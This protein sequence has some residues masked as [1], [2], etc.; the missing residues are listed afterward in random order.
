M[1]RRLQILNAHDATDFIA[2]KTRDVAVIV[3]VWWQATGCCRRWLAH[4]NCCFSILE[5]I[6]KLQQ[7][8]QSCSTMDYSTIE[9]EVNMITHA[10]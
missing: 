2:A 1:D 10:H 4:S 3:A 5:D 9:V 6:R 7:H 8:K